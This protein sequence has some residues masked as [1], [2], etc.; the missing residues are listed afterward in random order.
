MNGERLGEVSR[1]RYGAD[2]KTS[3]MGRDA[4]EVD[5]WRLAR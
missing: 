4:D 3:E 5:S 1:I 2:P